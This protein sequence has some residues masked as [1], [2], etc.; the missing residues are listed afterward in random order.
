MPHLG[1]HFNTG[2]RKLSYLCSVVV[3]FRVLRFV[4]KHC[5]RIDFCDL[6]FAHKVRSFSLRGGCQGGSPPPLFASETAPP[7]PYRKSATLSAWQTTRIL[8]TWYSSDPSSVGKILAKSVSLLF[9]S[10]FNYPNT[11]SI[12][13]PFQKSVHFH[14]YAIGKS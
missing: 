4:H 5:S 1:C 7:P 9:R 11:V 12:P 2:S 14:F 3:W 10:V 8:S 6:P 13:H